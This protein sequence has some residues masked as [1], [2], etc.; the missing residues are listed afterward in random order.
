MNR[1]KKI[2]AS[3]IAGVMLVGGLVGTTFA[4]DPTPT[5]GC[6][7]GAAGGGRGGAWGMGMP[8]I[9][10]TVLGDLGI[11]QQELYTQRHEGKSLSQIAQSQ[12]VN[13]DKLVADM[14]A[15]KKAQLDQAV[16][17]GRITQAQADAAYARMQTQISGGVTRTEVGPNRPADAP[18]LGLGPGAGMGPGAQADQVG[19]RGQFGPGF[20]G[21]GGAGR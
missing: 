13:A 6:G 2:A 16:K 5:T 8:A 1:W 21:R 3:S 17:D 9:G 20:A 4:A 10:A 19:P 15:A 11:S 18:R 14:L 12:G 7:P